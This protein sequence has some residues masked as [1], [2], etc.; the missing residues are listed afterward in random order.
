MLS[1]AN[2]Y[3]A[4]TKDDGSF[5]I[6]N[7]PAGVPLTFKVWQEKTKWL[8]TVTV[9][10]KPEKWQKGKLNLTLKEGET[11]DL[12]VALDASTLP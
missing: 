11:I 5:E 10:N 9:N 6:A 12:K 4:V 8:Q 2:P 3:F 1:R 7:V